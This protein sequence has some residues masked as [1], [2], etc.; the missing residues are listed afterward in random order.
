MKTVFLI[1]ILNLTLATGYSQDL[2][3]SKFIAEFIKLANDSTNLTYPLDNDSL[4]YSVAK[5]YRSLIDSFTT[6]TKIV[7]ED[8]DTDIVYMGSNFSALFIGL[9]TLLTNHIKLSKVN[10]IL[11]HDI[12]NSKI[13]ISSIQCK[14]Y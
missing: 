4:A 3:T 10:Y 8:N 7:V 14:G 12:D 1:L 9:E 13:I 2:T 11:H 6:T 5:E